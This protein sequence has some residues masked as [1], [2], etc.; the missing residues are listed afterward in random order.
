M[1][2][3]RLAS[4]LSLLGWALAGVT[5]AHALDLLE[6]WERTRAHDPQMAV[7]QAT[8]SSAEAFQT[9]AASVWRPSVLASA[10]AG[11]ASAHTGTTGAQFS[12]PGFGQSNGVSF[13][14]SIHQGTA[15]RWS[16]S[17]KQPLYNPERNAQQAQLGKNAELAVLRA[18]LAQQDLMLLTA[19]RYFDV[20][21]AERKLAVLQKQYDAVQRAWA[22]A[23]DRY[24]LGDAPV[25]DTHEAA[26]R[27]RG[28]QAQ[29]L[30]AESELQ[31]ARVVLSESTGLPLPSL[32]IKTPG[33][34]AVDGGAPDL[35]ALLVQA[36][37][38]NI[39][40]QMQQ[41]GLAMAQQEV[42]KHRLSASATLDAIAV[43]GHDRLSGQ[44]DFGNATNTQN[45]QMIGLS[46]NIPLY[47]GGWREGKL[48][49]S[50]SA[51]DKASAELD[52]I[53]TQ[54]LQQTRMAWLALNSGQA[55]VTALTEGLAA[56]RARLDATR[57]GR[58][59]GDRTTLE[60]LNAE[61]DAAA[62]ELGLLSAQTQ[63]LLNRLKVDALTGNL[64]VQS[65]QRTNARLVD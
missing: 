37:D 36:Q 38:Q 29:V 22:E 15:T 3:P 55:Q 58:Q 24:A 52:L 42:N 47:T 5:S 48:K 46:L 12:A 31:M 17:A 53:R 13:S 57:L 60:L 54:V 62:A 9:Q 32:K 18:D 27:A 11:I 41:A 34:K 39:G 7:V 56:S 8:R 2:M 28:L 10:T 14:T 63:V 35:N 65:L 51:Q 50:L 30:A 49:E 44:G 61:N 6:T 21:L 25:T 64:S 40:L 1:R 33:S 43:A 19:Q 20:G 26:A 59:V 16:L 4:Q 45:Q 23:K